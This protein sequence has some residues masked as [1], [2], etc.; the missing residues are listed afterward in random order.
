MFLGRLLLLV[1]VQ[2][3]FVAQARAV[4]PYGPTVRKI[5]SC[6]ASVST[7]DCRK[8][9]EKTGCE[10]IRELEL[11]NA[12]VIDVSA[13]Q[14]KSADLELAAAEEVKIVEADRRV[15]WL[16]GLGEFK[17][18]DI[19][20]IVTPFR[21]AVGAGPAPKAGEDPEQPW[22]IQRVNAAGAWAKTQG[23]G[24][25]VAV[26]DTGIDYNHPD[27]KGNVYGGANVVNEAKPKDYMDDQGH[28]THVSGTIAAL[29]DGKGVVGVAPKAK[30]FGV[31]VLD[32]EGSGDY[33][34]I[35]AGIQW[36]VKNKMQVANMSLGA[37]EGM[38]ALHEAIKAATS[39]GLL[40]VA[41]AG[42]N[43]GK[44][45]YPAAYPE[46]VAVSASNSADKITSFS[47]RGPEIAFIAPGANIKSSF[48]GGGYENLDGTS[49]ACPHVVGLAALAAGLGHKG[50]AIRGALERAATPLPG[51][52]ATQQGKG[53]INAA[54]IK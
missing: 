42:N 45:G 31:K 38:D 21:A 25:R 18:P 26:I 20:D 15:N 47:S 19:K 11:I 49:M 53:F 24:V 7:A 54:K 48:M 33:S 1:A 6:K 50:E 22:G 8:V 27:L 16:K 30:L 9:A 14:E 40:I 36:A 4:C 3:L 17:L 28:G 37:E 13:T 44:V 2:T 41:A 51:L 32:A 43:G 23:A 35:I 29:K 10:V 52:T 39:A 34:T 5:V 12:I 46:V